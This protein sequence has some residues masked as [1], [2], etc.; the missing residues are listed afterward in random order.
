[1]DCFLY[2]FHGTYLCL[3][4]IR[5]WVAWPIYSISKMSLDFL[6]HCF[7]SCAHILAEGVDMQSISSSPPQLLLKTASHFWSLSSSEVHCLCSR[8]TSDLV[9]H[10]SEPVMLLLI[11]LYEIPL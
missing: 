3:F 1:M 2:S 4:P 5:T 7:R 10:T 6:F 9:K 8:H 11:H